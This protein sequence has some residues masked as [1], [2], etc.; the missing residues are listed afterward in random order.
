MLGPLFSLGRIVATPGALAAIS[1]SRLRESLLSHQHGDW[2][3]VCAE[4][5]RENDL[6]VTKGFRI[7]SCYA[8]DR[9]KPAVDDNR[10]WILTE[11]DRSVT[12]VLLPGDY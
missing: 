6:S 11:A 1:E 4:D 12:T 2:G 7:L 8:I 10:L 5:A 9:E 3:S